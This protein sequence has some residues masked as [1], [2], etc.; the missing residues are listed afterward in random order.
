[1]SWPVA[2]PSRCARRHSGRAGRARRDGVANSSTQPEQRRVAKLSNEA[3]S[4]VR[5]HAA[6]KRPRHGDHLGSRRVTATKRRAPRI[7]DPS[8]P[9]MPTFRIG[10]VNFLQYTFGWRCLS[11]SR[12][13]CRS[14]WR[15][16]SGG[17]G[18][19]MTGHTERL[20]DGIAGR[21][22]IPWAARP[23]GREGR[24]RQLRLHRRAEASASADPRPHT[25]RTP[26]LNPVRA[27]VRASTRILAILN[28]GPS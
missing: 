21:R 27:V 15:F 12:R 11:S 20:C 5:P 14:W 2:V 10:E 13:F 4:T 6:S 23:P 8:T 3:A 18:E 1:V 22:P 7:G 26:P 28:G 24:Q 19:A 17:V 25:S 9:S 16:R